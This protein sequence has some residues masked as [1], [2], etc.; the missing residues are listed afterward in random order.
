MYTHIF[1]LSPWNE[2]SS[3]VGKNQNETKRKRKEKEKNESD[4]NGMLNVESQN[5][6]KK[7]RVLTEY[8]LK[9]RRRARQ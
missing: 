9:K 6:K 3:F 2:K 1:F 8:F 7:V 4:A 5:R